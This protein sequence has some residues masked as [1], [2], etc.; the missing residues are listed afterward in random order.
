[1]NFEIPLGDNGGVPIYTITNKAVLSN[2]IRPSDT[3]I[4]T[5]A[6]G[7]KETY[8]FNEHEIADYLIDKGGIKD[9]LKKDDLMKIINS[10]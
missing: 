5:I 6:L 2:I 1:M 4:K 7:L 10:L 8:K 3:Y 9:S